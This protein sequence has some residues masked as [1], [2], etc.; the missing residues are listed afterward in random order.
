MQ[1]RA[2]AFRE[3]QSIFQRLERC[4]RKIERHKDVI[5]LEGVALGAIRWKPGRPDTALF[6]SGLLFH[7]SKLG[8]R[9]NSTLQFL[10][11]AYPPLPPSSHPPRDSVTRA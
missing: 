9:F 11:N 10:A 5:S 3:R 2:E 6:G 7:A 1:L 4:P 8:H